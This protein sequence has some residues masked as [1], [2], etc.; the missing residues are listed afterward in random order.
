M[1]TQNDELEA[2]LTENQGKWMT[3]REVYD[4]MKERGFVNL[5][6]FKNFR[7]SWCVR[8]YKKNSSNIWEYQIGTP[9]SPTVGLFRLFDNAT[10]AGA[11]QTCI[12]LCDSDSE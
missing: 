5:T 6:N 4:R 10:T 7:Q 8:K 9:D 12:D 11:G 1:K 2:I 3:L